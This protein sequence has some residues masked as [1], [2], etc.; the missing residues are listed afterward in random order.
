MAKVLEILQPIDGTIV[1][2]SEVND[3]LFN[4][5]MMGE[6]VAILPKDNCVYSPIDGEVAVIYESKHAVVI[7]SDSGIQLL[8]HIGLDTAK[9]E[10]RGFGSYV[11]VGD[12]VVAGDKLIFF[13]GEYVGKKSSLETPMVITN[14]ELI[15]SIEINFNCKN[16]KSK[17]ATVNLK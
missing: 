15:E 17:L 10:G 6:G 2:L 5:K 14:P 13:D 3:Y 12:K 7:K 16:A 8:I 1:P 9:L 4:K 11:K